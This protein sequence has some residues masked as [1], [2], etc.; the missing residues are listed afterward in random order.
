MAYNRYNFLKKVLK[1]QELALLHRRQELFF[2]EIYH[3]H[4]ENQFNISKRTFDSYM[5]INAKKQIKEFEQKKQETNQLTL[6]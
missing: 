3:L 1:I 5:G 4:V 2:K 6:F